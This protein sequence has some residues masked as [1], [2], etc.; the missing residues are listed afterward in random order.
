MGRRTTPQSSGKPTIQVA[1]PAKDRFVQWLIAHRS[2]HQGETVGAILEW[3]VSQPAS[4][5]QVVL[6]YLPPE[7]KEAYAEALEKMARDIREMPDDPDFDW[8]ASSQR[9]PEPNGLVKPLA[10]PSREPRRANGVESH[11]TTR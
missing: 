8:T 10:G 6:G 2:P 9:P 5:Q 4:V 3:F 11:S 1:K 7:M